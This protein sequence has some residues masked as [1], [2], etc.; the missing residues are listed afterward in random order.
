MYFSSIL[1][2]V[3][4]HTVSIW[5]KALSTHLYCL[6][7]FCLCMNS[8]LEGVVY[9]CLFDVDFRIACFVGLLV[10]IV[11]VCSLLGVYYGPFLHFICR[12]KDT[13]K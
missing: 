10:E 8:M 7:R 1:P 2:I 3:L 9:G 12:I 4:T 5:A 6:V 13:C 11:I